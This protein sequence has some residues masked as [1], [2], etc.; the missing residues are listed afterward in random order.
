MGAAV[1]FRRGREWVSRGTY[2]G[3]NKEVF[4]AEV[5]AILQA[6]R[7]LNERDE[8]GGEYTVFLD[9]QTATARVQHD[10][11]GPAQALARAVISVTDDTYERGNTL[12]LRW[13]PPHVGVG[14]NG[15]VDGAAEEVAGGEGGG[16]ESEYLREV[17]L[18]CPMRKTTEERLEATKEWV[19]ATWEDAIGTDPPWRKVLEG[20]SKGKEGVGWEVLPAPVRS[21]SHGRATPPSRTVPD[22]PTLAVWQRGK[23]D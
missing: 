16:A 18:A 9:A 19:R 2:L 23:A 5:F 12:S 22:R 3:R 14:G 6:I 7:L 20:F 1:A 15:R 11:C 21:R 10:R 17:S 4:G 8:T 13:T